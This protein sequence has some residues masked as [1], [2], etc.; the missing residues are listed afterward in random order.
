LRLA[1][2]AGDSGEDASSPKRSAGPPGQQ[3]LTPT[4][5]ALRD[6]LSRLES[7]GGPALAVPVTF[8]DVRRFVNFEDETYVRALIHRDERLGSAGGHRT[9]ELAAKA[10]RARRRRV[11]PGSGKTPFWPSV[12]ARWPLR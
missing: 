9:P 12:L 2:R 5:E 6:R 8:D 4:L 11:T 3:Q 10:V 7:P 1:T